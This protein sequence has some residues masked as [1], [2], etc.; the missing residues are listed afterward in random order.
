MV[1]IQKKVLFDNHV[2]IISIPYEERMGDWMQYAI[3][4]AQFRRRIEQTEMLLSTILLLKLNGMK[5]SE[6]N[7]S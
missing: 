2:R 3:D 5:T 7:C 6:V 4:R 1:K